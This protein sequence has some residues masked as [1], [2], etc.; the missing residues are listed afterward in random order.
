MR[1]STQV[2][3][4]GALAVTGAVL[5]VSTT[6][7][8]SDR[9]A[10]LDGLAE[11]R[12]DALERAA[13]SVQ[14]D[15]EHVESILLLARALLRTA[16]T[17]AERERELRTI[18][19]ISR[20][21]RLARAYD[22]AGSVEFE[23][24]EPTQRMSPAT[25]DR[26]RAVMDQTVER[27]YA[28]R[29]DRPLASEPIRISERERLRVVAVRWR[30]DDSGSEGFI[31][32]AVDTR[33]ILSRL[34]LA[35][36]DP[37][38]RL[39]LTGPDGT[40]EPFADGLGLTDPAALGPI[41]SVVGESRSG[42]AR[43]PPAAAARLGLERDDA[44]AAFVR[45]GV[46]DAQYIAVTVTSAS[47]VK[48]KQR[49]I[50]VRVAAASSAIMLVL[51]A[52]GGWAFV[53]GRRAIAL[54]EALRHAER[55]AHEHEKAEKILDSVP[56]LVAALSAEGSFTAVNRALAE[57]SGCRSSGG[58]LE[59]LFANASPPALE[60]IRSLL[61]EAR[62][63]RRPGSYFAPNMNLFGEEG[64]FSLY[65]VPLEHPLQE[66]DMLLVIE[67]LTR[68]G[69]LESQLLRAEK[70]AT[71]GV[72]S[73]G[74]AHEIGTPLGIARGRAEYVISKLPPNDPSR[75]HLRLVLEQVD[76]VTRTIRQLLDFT[77]TRSLETQPVAV[78]PIVDRVRELLRFELERRKL[79][80]EIELDPALAPLQAAP[81]QLQQVLLNL[82]LN[83]CQ[84]S[85]EGGRIK[86]RA[87]RC[88][89]TDAL[90]HLAIEDE[91][92]GIPAD[93]RSRV[94]D[95]FFTTKKRG[96]GSGLGLTIVQQIVANHG[97]RLEL[98]SEENRG[99]TIQLL[100]PTA[101][102]SRPE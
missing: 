19:S 39:F 51:A 72:L 8:S 88:E 45:F 3:G 96:Q 12:H 4:L 1:G 53:S 66:T 44:V 57:R 58:S 25:L 90:Q 86:L 75:E 56:T 61:D 74:V 76:G 32:L 60:R 2:I 33:A 55:I 99:T 59:V 81:D 78:A 50:L 95:P 34:R 93:S 89:T 63:R 41:S 101:R 97:A 49:T 9:K 5:F 38:T 73:A 67:D 16:S 85:S 17:A 84:A 83:A 100:W 48:E 91:G 36:T 18:I 47:I 79:S 29:I 54:R 35:A 92:I 10:L 31:A 30:N 87:T 24:E 26:V 102:V 69:A 43:F 82:L 40:V 28:G 27:G 68:L 98:D 21:H 11:N 52:F 22:R 13:H 6:V 7:F 23:V 20:E 42:S 15:L 37:S 62:R 64:Q 77:R 46:G 94:F 65:A 71:V 80:L 14:T 70:L